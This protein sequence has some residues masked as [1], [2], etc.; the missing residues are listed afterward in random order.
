MRRQLLLAI[1]ALVEFVGAAFAEPRVVLRIPGFPDATFANYS[2]VVLP[3]HLTAPPEVWIEDA[4]GEIQLSSVRVRLNDMP[5]APFLSLNPLPRGARIIVRIGA[6]LSPEYTLR[7]SGENVLAVEALD[8]TKVTYQGLFYLVV[9]SQATAPR[10]APARDSARGTTVKVPAQTYP[11]VVRLTSE[12]PKTTAH[13]TITLD[14]EITDRASLRRV[15]IEVNGRDV[16]EIVLENAQPVRKRDGF[17]PRTQPPGTVT[18]D[19]RR[20]VISIPVRL[21]KDLSVVAVRAENAAGL[22]TRADRAIEVTK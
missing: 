14:A 12:W 15:V 13:R 19:G 3:P 18:G 21:T 4:L 6:S 2:A 20:L 8:E 17:I 11:P 10:V 9:D 5:M 22:R 16:E 7:A 1:A